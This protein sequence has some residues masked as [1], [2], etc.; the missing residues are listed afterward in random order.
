MVA[1]CVSCSAY[2]LGSI[3]RHVGPTGD[4]AMQCLI[5]CMVS[6][7]ECVRRAATWGIG[8]G[9]DR[10]VPP[11]LGL[12]VNELPALSPLVQQ[13]VR[14]N[15]AYAL[16]VAVETVNPRAVD[17]L[18][19]AIS[20]S[21][22]QLA[23]RVAELPADEREALQLSHTRGPRGWDGNVYNCVVEI[24]HEVTELRKTIATSLL[25]LG[26]LGRLG[27]TTEDSAPSGIA[28]CCIAHP[29]GLKICA[30]QCILPFKTALLLSLT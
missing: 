23:K 19:T 8:S 27:M 30:I 22:T 16:H 12:L 2:T 9:G 6:T 29:T 3:I 21:E 20:A 28:L 4:T 15:A 11:L 14:T 13:A 26:Q 7:K 1:A 10:V 17:A 24:D 25:A 18:E 5:S